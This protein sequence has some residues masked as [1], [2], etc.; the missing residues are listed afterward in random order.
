MSCRRPSP[1]PAPLEPASSALI[2]FP[3]AALSPRCSAGRRL[4][5]ARRFWRHGRR[6][7][8]RLLHCADP[9]ISLLPL[10]HG[11]SLHLASA[12]SAISLGALA[13]TPSSLPGRAPGG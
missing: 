9:P 12:R 7:L 5:P 6:A 1:S 10:S 3:D 8:G 13:P 11:A 4:L 2:S